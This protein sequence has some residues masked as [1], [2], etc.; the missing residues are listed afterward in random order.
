M[1]KK[2]KICKKKFILLLPKKNYI[3]ITIIIKDN[4]VTA[5]TL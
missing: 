3:L 1:K 4:V 5:Y 2:I